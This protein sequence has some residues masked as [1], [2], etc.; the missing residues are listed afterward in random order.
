MPKTMSKIANVPD[1][2]EVGG[3]V[4]QQRALE[5]L[6]TTSKGWLHDLVADGKI[7]AAY[8]DGRTLM[9][10]KRSIETFLAVHTP[11]RAGGRSSRSNPAS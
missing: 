11:R 3:Y 4:N 8:F 2:P 10:D 1:M 5:L 6:G 7:A 9:Y